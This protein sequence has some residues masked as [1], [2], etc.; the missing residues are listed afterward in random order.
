MTLFLLAWALLST[1][2][3]FAFTRAL[4]QRPTHRHPSDRPHS[5]VSYREHAVS[6]GNINH[7]GADR[8]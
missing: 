3:A 2:L 5:E 4:I 8:L 6:A 7:E 1:L